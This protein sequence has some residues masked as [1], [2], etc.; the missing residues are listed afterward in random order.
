[1]KTTILAYVIA[2]GGAAM[3]A[4]G[5]WGLYILIK[6]RVAERRLM[7]D[8]IPT[9]QTIAVG[10]GLIGVAQA[11]RLFDPLASTPVNDLRHGLEGEFTE[12]HEL[13][14][15]WHVPK[16]MIGRRLSQEEAKRLLTSNVEPSAITVCGH[17]HLASHLVEL[18]Q[19]VMHYLGAVFLGDPVSQPN[20]PPLNAR[21]S[22]GS[23]EASR[24]ALHEGHRRVASIA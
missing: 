23:P 12:G 20:Q 10:F 13:D 18:S 15:K 7:R 14:R 17:V 9:I 6:E 5:L 11:L 22:A 19:T 8:Y 24:E 21:Q 16:A 2:L 4:F 1:M 3:I